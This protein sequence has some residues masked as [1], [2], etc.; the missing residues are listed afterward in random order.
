MYQSKA[1]AS[2]YTVPPERP[3]LELHKTKIR[4][5]LNI[6]I[7]SSSMEPLIFILSSVTQLGTD[8]SMTG[9]F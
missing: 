8:R 7:A 9:Q 6:D 5:Y 4:T 3:Y 2:L 1:G